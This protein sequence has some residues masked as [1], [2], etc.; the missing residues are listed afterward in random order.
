MQP[1][2]TLDDQTRAFLS[3]LWRGGKFAYF[4]TADEQKTYTNEQGDQEPIKR[5]HWF[6]TGKIPQ[7]PKESTAHLY[8]SVNPSTEKRSSVQRA[9]MSSISSIATLFAEYDDK[10]WTSRQ[11]ILD[12]IETLPRQPSVMINSGGG[13]HC[14]WLL[15]EP[16]IIDSDEDRQYAKDIS[17]RWVRFCEGDDVKDLTRVLRLPGSKN[18]KPKYAPNY[19]LVEYVYCDLD[20]RYS[21]ADLVSILP[22]D[23]DE[24]VAQNAPRRDSTARSA[25][26]GQGSII[27]IYNAE[28]SIESRLEAAGYVPRGK[29]Y[30]APNADKSTNSSVVILDDNCSYHWDT[31][32]ELADEHK[33]SAFDVY[34]HFEHGGNAKAAVKAYMHESGR[35]LEVEYDATGVACCPIHHTPLP[36]AANGNGYKC[37]EKDA[38]SE[39]CS[40]YWKGTDM[41]DSK[42]LK[43]SREDVIVATAIERG[44]F[45]PR[46]ITELDMVDPPQW[47]LRDELV[48]GYNFLYGPSGSGKTFYA[49]DLA[50]RVATQIGT[51]VY[52]PTEDVGGLRI[53]TTAW[54]L[55][56]DKQ[57]PNFHWI[58]AIREQIDLTNPRDV[59]D[60][61]AAL[62]PLAPKLTI[63]DTLAM[64]HTG[65]EN[66]ETYSMV[67]RS[68]QRIM[69]EVGTYI[70]LVHHTGVN[71]GR[72]RG[73]TALMGN[74]DIKLKVSNDD[75][76][77]KIQN[78]KIR[79]GIEP[80]PK[81]MRL[82]SVNTGIKDDDGIDI[83]SA[84]IRPAADVTMRGAA[85][86]PRLRAVLESLAQEVFR[87][88]GARGSQLMG[89]FKEIPQSSFYGIMSKLMRLGFVRQGKKGDPF[90][91]TDNGRDEIAPQYTEAPA[92]GYTPAGY[93]D[94]GVEIPQ[95]NAQLQD[96]N[97]PELFPESP[98]ESVCPEID[99]NAP[100]SEFD[101][102]PRDKQT[103][104]RLYLRSGKDS[105]QERAKELCELYDVDYNKIR[106]E[107]LLP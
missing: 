49:I 34:C 9:V 23:Q 29:R 28:V 58:N 3:L 31:G 61:I 85:L 38:G 30:C 78:E 82:T 66:N 45:A 75:G 56:H 64:A 92:T 21:L 37:H 20:R 19:P 95:H 27:D 99:R 41:P 55:A 17:R 80:E 97:E 54:R 5:S 52:V 79:N 87:E 12:Y 1:H 7:P 42:T 70:L 105:D 43:L 88:A 67:N 106:Q 24:S 50:G 81:L 44:R 53:R 101:F 68:I 86:T 84:I 6:P 62:R 32:D 90:Y 91:I 104:L 51:V 69:V 26:N 39:W 73:G 60:L 48:R 22:A 98:Q 71:E 93:D 94:S 4:W 13:V 8:F 36:R 25:L 40:F 2:I 14:Y 89:S 63:L 16:Y 46:P 65:D 107:S 72:E 59:D 18:I 35:I 10:A 77:I 15:D 33:H 47:L 74:V 100:D 76:L 96:S 103:I 102:V 11:A 83:I 57:L